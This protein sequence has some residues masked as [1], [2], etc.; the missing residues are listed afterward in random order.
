VGEDGATHHGVFDLAFLR[1]IPNLII[2]APRNEVEL[3]NIMYTAQ[4]GL[5]YPIAIRYPRGRGHEV[6]W[7]Q[8]FEAIEIGKGVKLQNGENLVVLSLGTTAYNVSKALV[9]LQEKSVAHYDMRFVKPLDENLLH[10]IFKNHKTIVT[11]EDGTIKGGFGSTI[12]EFAAKHNYQ[13]KIE[14]LGVPDIFIDHGTK[15][16]LE[17]ICGIDESSLKIKFENLLNGY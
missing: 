6:N 9:G 3:R 1:C 10:R 14:I 5:N 2:F 7:K 13:N 16:E 12:L 8:P 4:L 17:H 15:S 11:V